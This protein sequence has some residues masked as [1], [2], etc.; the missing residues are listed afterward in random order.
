MWQ[1][2]HPDLAT[3]TIA[4]ICQ[5]TFRSE[6][7]GTKVTDAAGFF[8]VLFKAIDEHDFSQDRIPGQAFLVLPAAVPFVSSGVGKP[9]SR[10]EDYVLREYRGT[11]SAFLKREFAC[12]TE[13]C[14]A[15][16]YTL[17]AYLKDP[18][19]TPEEIERM[20]KFSSTTHVL[21]AVLASGS[22]QSQLSPYRFTANLA[23]GNHEAQVWTADEIRQKS[24]DIMT[25]IG[26]CVSVAD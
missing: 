19:V 8:R 5:T 22:E 25:Y 12:K 26:N 20:A 14:A 23:G 11:V 15:V 17:D 10:P 13:Q 18:D 7:I 4:D 1:I 6:A 2:N 9:T 24:R 3:V 21:V 16:V